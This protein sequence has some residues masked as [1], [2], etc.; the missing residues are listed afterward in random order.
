MNRPDFINPMPGERM[1]AQTRPLFWN[2]SGNLVLGIWL[3]PV[4]GVGLLVL[5]C[6]RMCIKKTCYVVTNFRVI[7]KT[8]WLNTKQTQIRIADIRGVNIYCTFSQ[9]ILGIGDVAIGTA[10]TR[11]AEI[12]MRGVLDPKTFVT[13]INSQL[14]QQW[15]KNSP[16]L[17]PVSPLWEGFWVVS[18]S[19]GGDCRRRTKFII[20]G[21]R[22]I[23][24]FA[25]FLSRTFFTS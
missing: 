16:H 24:K 20:E 18:E 7:A 3:I 2:Y 12:V 22:V 9:R 17:P 4:I 11:G 6:T 13:A 10:A 25:P 5:L 8:G 15:K 1:V 14:M 23:I 19:D 21:S